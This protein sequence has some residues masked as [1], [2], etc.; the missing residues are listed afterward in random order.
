MSV[1]Q[2]GAR[3]KADGL[4][5]FLQQTLAYNVKVGEKDQQ[6]RKIVPCVWGAP[7]IGKTSIIKQLVDEDTEVV[8]IP[9][10]QF[11]EMGDLHGLPY[12]IKNP[13]GTESTGY[14]PPSWVPT[15]TTKKYVI[16][17]DDWNR[18]DIRIIKGCMQL[19]QNGGTISWQFPATATIMLTG[20]P[21]DGEML[22][23]GIDSA[24]M[25]RVRHVQ[26]DPDPML[27]AEWANRTGEVD[28]R[29]ITFVLRYK[30]QFCPSAPDC[31][32][33]PRTLTEYGEFLK[34]SVGLTDLDIKLHA[35]AALDD[36]T[37]ILFSKF[38]KDELHHLV[39]PKDILNGEWDVNV[40][41]QLV[42]DGKTDIIHMIVDRLYVEIGSTR[43]TDKKQENFEN[44]LTQPG[45]PRDM[46]MSIVQRL[47][48]HDK[49]EAWVKGEKLSK[50]A[51]EITPEF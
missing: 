11:E 34:G 51:I 1:S 47:V 15:D 40:I 3:V 45:I 12:K 32:T 50:I 26:L 36:G 5:R 14:A 37:A 21:D 30:E 31:K 27:W 17:F 46:V 41:P 22:V 44:F 42:S 49:K 28:N 39:D 8:D 9:L 48:K 29:I 43:R 18:A 25:T 13:D 38:I 4:E 19:L 2:Y 7:G 35:R 10:A 23:T 20:N 33:N 6:K 24:I 16:L